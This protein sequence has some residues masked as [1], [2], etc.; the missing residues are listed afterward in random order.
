MTANFMDINIGSD[1]TGLKLLLL[2]LHLMLTPAGG[3][4]VMKMVGRMSCWCNGVDGNQLIWWWWWWRLGFN[5]TR[6][7]FIGRT[8]SQPTGFAALPIFPRSLSRQLQCMCVCVF[9]GGGVAWSALH[10]MIWEQF[11]C[12]NR[13]IFYTRVSATK[14]RI[15]LVKK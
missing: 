2:L 7:D 12:E 15:S 8:A 9:Q 1:Y 4:C 6:R 13:Q 5:F 11:I 14:C 3:R 10:L